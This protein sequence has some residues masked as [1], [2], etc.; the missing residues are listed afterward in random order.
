M[1]MALLAQTETE[2]WRIVVPAVLLILVFV[3]VVILWQF[4]GLWL[5]A[6]VSRAQVSMLELIGMRLQK[7]DWA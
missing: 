4:F 2:A 5:Q 6:W 3:V 7:V 1:L